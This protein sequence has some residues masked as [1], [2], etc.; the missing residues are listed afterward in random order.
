MGKAEEKKEKM[1]QL[2]ILSN[3]V[4]DELI[5]NESNLNSLN[6]V[7]YKATGKE[8]EFWE[9]ARAVVNS[10]SFLVINESK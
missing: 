5:E 8:S 1:S 3:R 10:L 7:L 6:L 4:V 2:S 9:W